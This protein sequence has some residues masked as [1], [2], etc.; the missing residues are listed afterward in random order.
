MY[1]MYAYSKKYGTPEIWLLYPE[2]QAMRNH[3]PIEFNS[4]DN[5]VVR[6]HF[7]NLE[8][9][10]DSMKE[11]AEKIELLKPLHVFEV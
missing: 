6:L 2:N 10:E 7:V 5:M 8:N 4:G 9:I 11:L 1:Q 3:V